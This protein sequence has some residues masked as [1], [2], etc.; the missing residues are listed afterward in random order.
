MGLKKWLLRHKTVLLIDFK[1]PKRYPT[2]SIAS[3]VPETIRIESNVI[4]KS[5]VTLSSSIKRI[6][7]GVYIGNQS[8]ILNVSEIGN[9]SCVSH[10]VKIGLDNHRLDA[11]SINPLFY[12]ASK[13]IVADDN[14]VHEMPTK[15]EADVLISADSVILSGITLGVGCVIGANSFVNKDV[16]PYAVVAGSPA[17]II[18]YR[19]DEQTIMQLLKSEWWKKGMDELRNYAPYFNAPID[20]LKHLK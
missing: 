13:G 15:I 5:G 17:K 12:D 11:I 9:Y 3:Y 18:K 19:F 14:K 2:C 10:N 7:E 1:Y 16:P 8:T 20:F 4:I 6:G